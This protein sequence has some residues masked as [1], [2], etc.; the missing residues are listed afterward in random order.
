MASQELNKAVVY[1]SLLRAI[2]LAFEIVPRE[3]LP[4]D[5]IR[6]ESNL[7]SDPADLIL[8]LLRG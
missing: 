8:C 5:C 6:P 7:T 2:S 1:P 4:S 3:W